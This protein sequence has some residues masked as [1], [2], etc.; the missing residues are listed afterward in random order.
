MQNPSRRRAGQTSRRLEQPRQSP[1]RRLLRSLDGGRGR[2]RELTCGSWGQVVRTA[3]NGC[4]LDRVM[5]F[6]INRGRHS[7]RTLQLLFGSDPAFKL[8]GQKRSG[9]AI[10]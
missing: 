7:P 5:N 4:R 3:R 10:F 2:A 8:H 1:L 6:V 9:T